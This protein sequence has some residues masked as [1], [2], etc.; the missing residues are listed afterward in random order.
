MVDRQAVSYAEAGAGEIET[1]EAHLLRSLGQLLPQSVNSSFSRVAKDPSGNLVG[2]ITA[3]TSYGWLLIKVLWVHADFRGRGIGRRLMQDA[4][5][6]GLNH[7]CHSAWL[8][9]SN[10]QAR[11][12]YEGLGYQ[13]FGKLE[14]ASNEY[15]PD[16]CR[17]FMKK[18][19]A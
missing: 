10:P 2:G 1:L 12:F 17:W 5:E 3:S 8:E 18:S 19:I 15:P 9:T 16:H 13:M 7:D 6:S 4:E 11:R 14:N